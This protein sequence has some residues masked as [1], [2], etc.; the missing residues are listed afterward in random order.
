MKEKV[1]AKISEIIDLDFD[2]EKPKDK[3]LAHYAI[4]LGFKLAKELRKSPSEIAASYADKF[5]DSEI[6]EVSNINGYVNFKLKG[7]ILNELANDALEAGDK[8]GA[9]LIKNPKRTYLEYVSANP[10]GPLHVGHVRGAVFG[11]TL[12]RI[13]RHLGDYFF[14]EYYINDAGNQIDLLG[15]SVSLRAKE[16][17]GEDVTYPEK[18]Y[19]G[20]YIDE[21]IEQAEAKFGKEIFYDESRNLELAEFAKD[22][23][24][25]IIDKD[26][27]DIGVTFNSWASE[28]SFYPKLPAT[29]ERFKA[30]GNAYEKDGS[31]YIA[32]SKYGDDADRVIIRKDGRPTYMAGDSVYHDYKYQYDGGFDKI[33]NIWGADHHGYIARLRTAIHCLG[34][35]AS[36]F[37]VILTQMVA[38]LKDGKPFKISKR[39]GT[40]ILMSDI[41]KEI[42]ADAL[43][44]IFIS[45][46]LNTYLKFDV[47]ELKKQDSSNPVF[48][49]N[50]AY[51][52]INQL[53]AKANKTPADVANADLGKLDEAAANLLFE[54][55]TLPEVL[56]DAYNS[57]MLH[58]VA[59]YLKNLSASFHKLYNEQKVV[60]SELEDEYLKAFSVVALTIKVGFALLG[61]EVKEKMEH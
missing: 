57:Q 10:T 49:I 29:I 54:A 1:K 9:N 2:L 42:G 6:F 8:F 13:A 52:R 15:I 32:S 5:K 11:D 12:T 35:D 44:F 16:K 14:T 26:L 20:D 33:V 21:I 40:A 59:D 3:N 58:K 61:I 7:K 51:A 41:T 56:L 23:V 53:F 37:E 25:V 55:L 30:N 43:R 18:Y 60:G 19:R 47:A 17:Y 45:K 50:Y 36:K 4:P 39:A 27:K 28:K 46:A 34:H 24:L 48:Y 22:I 38:V 31:T